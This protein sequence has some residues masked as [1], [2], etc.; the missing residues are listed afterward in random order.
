M[1][2]IYK[3][4]DQSSQSIKIQKNNSEKKIDKEKLKKEN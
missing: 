4:Y 1:I 3:G 2:K